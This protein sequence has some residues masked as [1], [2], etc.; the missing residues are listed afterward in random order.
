V[1]TL[2]SEDFVELIFMCRFDLSKMMTAFLDEELDKMTE[3]FIKNLDP[4][5]LFLRKYNLDRKFK[6]DQK[7]KSHMSKFMQMHDMKSTL[8]GSSSRRGSLRIE[9]SKTSSPRRDS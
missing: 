2:D 9:R 1:I 5:L 3:V 4:S 7:I 6:R 8:S